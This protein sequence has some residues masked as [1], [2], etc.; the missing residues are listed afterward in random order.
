MELAVV[1]M[2]GTDN[3]VA[4]LIVCMRMC[5]SGREGGAEFARGVLTVAL[6]IA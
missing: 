4:Q 5:A 3:T 2:D 6:L 1:D